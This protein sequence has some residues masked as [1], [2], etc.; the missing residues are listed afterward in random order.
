MTTSEER[1]RIREAIAARPD[2]RQR[3]S[4]DLRA[5]AAAYACR[6]KAEGRTASVIAEELG[7]SQ[8]TVGRWLEQ[9][10]GTA[11][12]VARSSRPRALREVVVEPRCGAA[13]SVVS[14]SGYRVEG[15]SLEEAATLL[16][17]LG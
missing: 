17:A 5:R 9:G 13:L 7:V 8:P 15:V 10:S 6:R 4:A 2:Q 3:L 14:P 12:V 1:K 16:R 11:I